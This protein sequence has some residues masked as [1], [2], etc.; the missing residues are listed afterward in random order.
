[1]EWWNNGILGFY[2]A[3]LK[4]ITIHEINQSWKIVKIDRKTL[5]LHTE[6]IGF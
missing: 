1:M 6:V 4:N 2:L 5:D 3:P